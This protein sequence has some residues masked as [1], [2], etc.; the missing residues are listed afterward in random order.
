MRFKPLHEQ[1]IVITGASS[2]IGLATARAA[3]RG[4][5]AVVLAARNGEALTR[6]HAELM[7]RG[8][9]VAAIE[10]DVAD[11]EQVERI[12]QFA[13][14]MFGGFDTWVNNA[15]V[16]IYGPVLDVPLADQRQLFDVNYWGQVYG[17]TTAVRHLK[18]RGGVL[19]NIGSVTSDR[20]FP[21]QVAYSASKHAV[22]GFTDGLR[23]EVEHEGWPVAICLVKPAAI[24]TPFFDHARHYMDRRPA[25]PPPVYPPEEVAG[26]I[27]AC[28]VRPMRDIT[29]GGAARMLALGSALAPR[30]TDYVMER[31]MFDA[32]QADED[33]GRAGNLYESASPHLQYGTERRVRAAS[34]Y[35]RAVLSMAGRGLPLMVLGLAA[36]LSA[37]WARS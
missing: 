13:V 6:A 21:L 10:A 25:A 9:R 35:T 12:G 24:D 3:V 11:P 19:I 17:S 32:Q 37:R 8:A 18:G 33:A 29:V 27:L 20:A 34:L 26:A 36:V 15:G 2:G 31:F 14:E 1:V 5:A 4:G 7:R 22:K 28:A 16:S 30:L 23:M